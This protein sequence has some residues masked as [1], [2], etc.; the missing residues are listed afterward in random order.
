M[1]AQ[2]PTMTEGG[3]PERRRAPLIDPWGRQI[4]Y[5]RLSLTDRCN[6]RCRY[7]MPIEGVEWMP[8]ADLLSFEELTRVGRIL[9]ELGVDKLRL[10]GGEPTLRRDLVQLVEQLAALPGLRDLALTTNGWRL[11]EL[12]E[13]LKEAGLTRLNISL[14]TLNPERFKELTGG[15]ELAPVLR[16]IEKVIALEWFPLKLNTVVVGG[17]NDHEVADFALH[18]RRLPV[19]IRFIEYMPFDGG[20]GTSWS[21]VPWAVVRERLERAGMELQEDQQTERGPARSFLVA[22]SPLRVGTI[23]PLSKKFCAACNRIRIGADGKIRTCL[24]YEPD[25]VDLRKLL[26]AGEDDDA[27]AAAIR[28]A[29]A[30]KPEAHF[31]TMEGGSAFQGAM[32]QIGG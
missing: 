27:L 12:A 9:T 11:E 24:A 13:P 29:V 30:G 7:C 28:H 18:F 6:F 17:L 19:H 16:G 10:T 21:P 23:A 22:G 32:I 15:G 1:S 5:V 4:R 3:R 8:R 2:H 26:R 25:G 20:G 31:A 14:D